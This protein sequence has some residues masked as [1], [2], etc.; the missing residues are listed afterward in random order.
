V[1]NHTY[2]YEVL[3]S[4]LQV[5]QSTSTERESLICLYKYSTT[6]VDNSTS[7]SVLLYRSAME[8]NGSTVVLQ[9]FW[10]VINRKTNERDLVNNR[11]VL[12]IVESVQKLY[13][14]SV[15]RSSHSQFLDLQVLV[16]TTVQQFRVGTSGHMILFLDA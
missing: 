9:D 14:T 3:N 6:V 8:N 5:Q 13:Y 16:A 11:T 12:G 1:V 2:E 4:T 7:I 15:A 10:N